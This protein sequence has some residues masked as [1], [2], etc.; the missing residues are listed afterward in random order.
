MTGGI[1]CSDGRRAAGRRAASAAASARW[2]KRQKERGMVYLQRWLTRE[3]M[4]RVGAVL[5]ENSSGAEGR[6]APG[7]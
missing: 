5:G 7:R 4:R 3:Q 2:R 6:N 1:G